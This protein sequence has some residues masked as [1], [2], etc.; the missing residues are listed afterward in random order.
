[1][2]E[3]KIPFPAED[4]FID[5]YGFWY[6]IQITASQMQQNIGD[7]PNVAGWPAYYQEP[8]YD[9]SWISSDT[10][11]KR[12]AFTDRMVTNGFARNGKKLLVD[13]VQYVKQLPAA[14]DPNKL[15]DELAL[16]LYAVDIPAEEKQYMKTG[17]LLQG[18]QGMASDHYWT[19]AWQKLQDKPDDAA[20]AK[21]VTNKLR[22]LL[23]YMMSL[24][25]YQ[26]M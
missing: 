11:P 1:V 18:L 19:D 4:S 20:N 12:T 13:P 15:I 9:K 23:K 7:P 17:I 26:L 14:G 5:Q 8:L 25:Q 22:N 3:Y 24:P 6:N 16:L 2:R 21:N 10:L